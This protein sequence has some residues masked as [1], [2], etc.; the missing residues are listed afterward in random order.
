MPTRSSGAPSFV[1]AFL[2]APFA[3]AVTAILLYAGIALFTSELSAETL[4][5]L[6]KVL[7][8]IGAGALIVCAFLTAVAGG[9]AAGYVR[10]RRRVPSLPWALAIGFVIG[11]GVFGLLELKARGASEVDPETLIYAAYAGICGL[12]TA[13]AFWRLGLRGRTVADATTNG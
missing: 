11:A 9:L 5:L 3:G 13:W 6:G 4:S 12:F 8:A 2:L 10:W 7:L 1:T